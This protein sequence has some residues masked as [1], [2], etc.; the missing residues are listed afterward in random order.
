[1]IGRTISHYK[2]LE[3]LGEGGMGIVY[4]AQ[5]VKL[6]RTVALKFLS[7]QALE[8]DS[9]KER[10]VNEAKAAAALNHP[11]ICTVYEIDETDKRIYI[12]MEYVECRTLERQIT[13][14]T[15]ELD[16]AVDYA[17]QIAEGLQEAHDKG[18]VHSD[19]K[20]SNILVT[21][22]CQAKI[23]DFGLARL[24]CEV[25]PAKAKSIMGTA[26]YMSPEQT[27]G[28]DLDNRTDIWSLGVILFEMVTG[29]HPFKG[30]YEQAMV[31]SILNEDPESP[32][33]IRERVPPDLDT[34][35]LKAL[36]KDRD[37]RYESVTEILGDLT[38]LREDM[39]A[40]VA[41][42][43]ADSET[44]LPSIAVLPFENLS[45]DAEQAY[46]C[47]GLA[48]EI[49]SALTHVEGLRV[50][51][52]SSAF[53]FRGKGMGI[54]EIGGE[55][56]V[57]ALLEGS[58]RKFENRIRVT[59]QLVNVADGYHIWSDKYD[60][61][62]EDIFAIQ[63]E[64]SLA[65]VR[66]L[67]PSLLSGEKERVLERHTVDVEAYNLYL[68][69]RWFWDKRTEEALKK[70]ID[71][72]K[73]AVDRDPSYALAYAGIADS[74]NDLP[75][76][77]SYPPASAYPKAKEAALKAL[78]LDD[79]HAEAH[80]S[81]GLIKAEYEWDWDGAEEEFKRALELNPAYSTARHW[82]ATLFMYLGRWDEAVREVRRALEPDPLCLVINRSLGMILC[83]AGKCDE[84]IEVL[85]RTIELDPNFVY[86]HQ[87]LGQVYL[88]KSVYDK[89][90]VEFGIEKD[91]L[92][93]W[94]PYLENWIGI[95]YAM[96]GEKNKARAVLDEVSR[97]S[98][99]MYVSPFQVAHLCFALG[100]NDRGFQ[101]LTKAF[102]E[103]DLWTR[104]LKVRSPLFPESVRSDPRFTKMLDKLRL[105]A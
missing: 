102:E 2:I 59:A 88:R 103:R 34:I 47:D 31:Y 52:R 4:K 81:L 71:Y 63:D 74:Y 62:L 26:A 104:F 96:K 38:K 57:G 42:A 91:S 80:A 43:V 7:R 73:Q 33:S 95:T 14:G 48:E 79:T 99:S 55:L 27:R 23:A 100:E 75:T 54:R 30:E 44:H 50:V 9:E 3:K 65:I 46:F 41:A 97:K 101:L 21:S 82:Y 77:S 13:D 40:G 25:A 92:G 6:D 93:S 84:A 66:N 18:I 85:Q 76:Y 11:N 12:A 60:S 105:G 8:S 10:F 16:D 70:A 29:R 64:I 90:L 36:V 53:A 94:N 19:I 58:V 5:D 86:T 68:K 17:I 78:D 32:A 56:R 83:A 24:C 98:K 61:T 20:P 15:V 51:A 49:M 45:P 87:L 37:S 72:F 67:K 28:D 89:A 22:K 39:K 69:G 1:M 35:V